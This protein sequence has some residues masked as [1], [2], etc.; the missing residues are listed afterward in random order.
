MSSFL[1]DV[2]REDLSRKAK[3]LKDQADGLLTKANDAQNEQKSMF[4]KII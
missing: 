3:D 2:K 4:C 1:Q